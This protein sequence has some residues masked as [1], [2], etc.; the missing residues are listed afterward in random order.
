MFIPMLAAIAFTALPARDEQDLRC[1][2]YLSRAA[3]QVDGELRKRV[4]GGAIW[5]FGRLAERSPSLDI[6][7][8]LGQILNSPRY[9]ER[10]YQADKQ[11]CHA[12]LDRFAIQFR[13]WEAANPG[14]AAKRPAGP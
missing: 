2:A 8:E 3:G 12:D 9:D 13:A 10:A 14:P 7:A 1:L 5:Y 11:R 6:Q 4:D